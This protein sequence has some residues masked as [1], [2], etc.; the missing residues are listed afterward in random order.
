MESH[1]EHRAVPGL[2]GYL[3]RF[4]VT[5]VVLSIVS[6]FV[7]GFTIANFWAALVAA[8]VISLIDYLVEMAFGVDAA[9]IGKGIKGFVITAV[10]L[11][12]AQFFVPTMITTIWGAVIAA[13]V[14]GVIDAILPGRMM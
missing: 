2:L 9:P 11:Y 8:V 3:I 6:F 4:L 7:P 12:V 13:A 10:I 5:A 14:I 1:T